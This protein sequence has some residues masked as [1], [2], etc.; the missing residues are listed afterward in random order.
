MLSQVKLIAEPWDLGEGGYQV[1]GFPP[2]WSDWNGRYRDAVRSYW[3]GD[4][5]L[6][7]ELASRLSGSSDIFAPGGRG[8]TAS[9]QLHHR[10]RRLH[11]AR[12]R[13]LQRQAQRGERRGQPRRRVAQPQLELRRRRTDRRP[14]HPRAAAAADAQ[15]PRDPLLLAGRADAGGAATRW[16]AR[17]A[18][19]TMRT[20]RTTRSR[21]CA[22]TST[23]K[24]R[25]LLDFTRRVIA[26]RNKHPLFRRLTFFR[27]RAVRD[28]DAKDIVWLKPEG[29]EMTD[30][31]WSQGH[32]RCL[33]A[34]LSGRGLSERDEYGVPVED[35]DLMLLFNAQRR[36]DRV[37]A[38]DERRRAVARPHRHAQRVG[39]PRAHDVRSGRRI[40]AAPPI[41]R[42]AVSSASPAI[43]RQHAMPFGATVT[44]D[45]VDFGLW[46]PRRAPSRSRSTVAS[47][48]WMPQAAAGT[49]TTRRTWARARDTAIASTA[50]C[51]YP[52]PRRASIPTMC[53]ARASSSTLA[54]LRGRDGAWRGR[55]WHEAVDLRAS[56]RDVL[57]R[58]HVRRRAVAARLS[59]RPRRDGDRADA[60][61]RFPGHAQLGLRRRAAVRA[62]CELRHARRPASRWSTPRTRAVS[63]CWSTSS[64]TTSARK[65]TTSTASRRRSSPTATRR[66]GAPRST[67]TA[68]RSTPVRD[69]FVHNALYW[70]EEF[71]VDGLRLDAVHA[72]VDDS[73]A[74]FPDRARARACARDRAASAHDPPRARERPQRGPSSRARRRRR[75]AASRTPRNGTTTSTTSSHHLLTGESVT[76]TTPTMRNARSRCSVDASPKASRSRAKRRRIASSEPRGEPSAHLA[77]RCVRQLPAEPRP[78]RQSRLR[79]AAARACA[80][81]RC[82]RSCLRDLPARALDPAAVHGRGVRGRFAVPVLLRLRRRSR[83]RRARWPARGVRGVSAVRRRGQRR[84]AFPIPAPSRRSPRAGSTG[85]RI[86]REPHATWLRLYRELLA[87]RAERI[88]PLLDAIVAGEAQYHA[89]E[90][91]LDVM[92]RCAMDARCTL[93]CD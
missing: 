76:A 34:H 15:L 80:A 10:A 47:C 67:S 75:C 83:H 50:S 32:A 73:V 60:A 16:A 90:Q 43:A 87:I 78:G 77:A 41:P 82:V 44:S 29:E 62:G 22:G 88:V 84:T 58:G 27:G 9:D 89:G 55:P 72:I 21:G 51:M 26:L 79:R 91:A 4:G 70:L 53:M 8:P 13:E 33:G 52:I 63:W 46:A 45:G 19:T 57:A 92:W 64:T 20:A 68:A 56:R 81:G 85:T 1:G 39:R 25:A 93:P 12:P 17:S 31:E 37:P 69:F 6:V 54:H 11:A 30:E 18:A 7:G 28:S 86:A 59:R 71:H 24:H 2:G 74:R 65:A 35:D 23:T 42:L 36:R 48:P 38:C 49:G 5:G 61:R 14:G 40:S 3:K 66:R